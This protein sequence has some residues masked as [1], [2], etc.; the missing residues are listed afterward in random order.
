MPW[1]YKNYYRVGQD[2]VCM[3]SEKFP[4]K[5]GSQ[6]EEQSLLEAS[7]SKRK[8]CHTLS[9]TQIGILGGA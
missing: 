6:P 4:E 1:F 5:A 9:K 2:L 3:L 8:G 7:F